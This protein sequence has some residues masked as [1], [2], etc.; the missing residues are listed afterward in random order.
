MIEIRFE[1]DQ[2][3]RPLLRPGITFWGL[4]RSERFISIFREGG[5]VQG[6]GRACH[7]EFGE[8]LFVRSQ[9]VWIKVFFLYRRRYSRPT[10]VQQFRT[11]EHALLHARVKKIDVIAQQLVNRGHF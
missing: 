5:R 10:Y 9:R 1:S 8:C 6:K 4:C 3:V 7:D 11:G 2:K